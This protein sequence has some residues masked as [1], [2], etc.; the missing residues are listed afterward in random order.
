MSKTLFIIRGVS[1]SGKTTLAA[2]LDGGVA[3]PTYHAEA[4]HFFMVDG[5]YRFDP[6]RLKEAHTVCMTRVDLAMMCGDYTRV[7]VSNTFTRVWEF[8]PYLDMAQ[9]RGW[10]VSVI[11]METRHAN[12]HGVPEESVQRMADRWEPFNETPVNR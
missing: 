10:R 7:V 4:D 8:Q 1:G 2:A 12:T 11:H 6:T 5:E 9:A 3:V